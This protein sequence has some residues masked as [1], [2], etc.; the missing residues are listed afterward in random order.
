[1][2]SGHPLPLRDG[3]S[4]SHTP[5]GRRDGGVLYNLA[6]ALCGTEPHVHSTALRRRASLRRATRQCLGPVPRLLPDHPVGLRGSAVLGTP[7]PGRA[8]ALADGAG[9]RGPVGARPVPAWAERPQC[10]GHGR[11]SLRRLGR[12][13]GGGRRVAGLAV[14][15]GD[16]A[17]RAAPALRRPAAGAA[18]AHRH[19]GGGGRAAPRQRH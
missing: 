4:R 18:G 11:V 12:R 10:D 9:V 6:E 2:L 14:P 8:P 19:V 3:L 17:G 15:G 13:R 16:R 7:C 1:M 5:A